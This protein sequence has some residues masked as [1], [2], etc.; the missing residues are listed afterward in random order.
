MKVCR[1]LKNQFKTC[2]G[3]PYLGMLEM[4]LLTKLMTIAFRNPE[5]TIIISIGKKNT[6]KFLAYKLNVK[7]KISP[8]DSS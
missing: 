2:G 4:A 7:F 5:S 8:R 3:V 1:K 6:I